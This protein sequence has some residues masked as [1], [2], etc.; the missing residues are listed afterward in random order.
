MRIPVFIEFWQIESGPDVPPAVGDHVEWGLLFKELATEHSHPHSDRKR[1]LLTAK[2]SPYPREFALGEYPTRLD[3]PGIALYWDAPR[4]VT[5]PV[6]LTGHVL[7]DWHDYVPEDF[8]LTRGVVLS[9]DVE[10]RCTVPAPLN[11]AGAGVVDPEGP[12][13]YQPVDKS[14]KWFD[15]GTGI[16]A[17]IELQPS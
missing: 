15:R 12:A 5:G 14:P 6:A 3:A 16:L 11:P 9:I 8:P 13:T 4:T 7:A 17:V 10:Y 1:V 2:A